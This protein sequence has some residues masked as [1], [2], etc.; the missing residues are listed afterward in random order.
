MP[1]I[2]HDTFHLYFLIGLGIIAFAMAF[3]R[4][5]TSSRHDR[6]AT[7]LLVKNALPVFMQDMMRERDFWNIMHRSASARGD[8]QEQIK[9]LDSLLYHLSA[10]EI[11]SFDRRFHWYRD[12]LYRW[13][14]WGA[15]YLLNGGCSDDTFADFRS[16]LVGQG[17][18]NVEAVLQNPEGIIDFV[19]PGDNWEG[20]QYCANRVYN[21]KTGDVLMPPFWKKAEDDQPEPEN[22]DE[23]DLWAGPKDEPAGEEWDEADLPSMF[24]NIARM[25]AK[26]S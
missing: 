17:R 1:A 21:Q 4:Q 15:V 23:S 14:L 10:L 26:S 7:Q 24:P 5:W 2:S 19:K 18:Q 25:V 8:L 9:N 12:K 11:V 20:L 22:N 3:R 6:E 16:W 13:D